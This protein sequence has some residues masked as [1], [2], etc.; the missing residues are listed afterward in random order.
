MASLRFTTDSLY[1][2]MPT[3]RTD[4]V[5]DRNTRSDNR[6]CTGRSETV[7]PTNVQYAYR[8]L[9]A[10]I[11]NRDLRYGFAIDIEAARTHIAHWWAEQFH[12]ARCSFDCLT[13][14]CGR[15]HSRYCPS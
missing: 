6:S 7:P 1:G 13:A 14:C 12:C 4:Y 15:E 9:R 10:Y 5:L 2:D 11:Q 8:P 3:G